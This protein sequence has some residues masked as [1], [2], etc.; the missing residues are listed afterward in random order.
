VKFKA[1]KKNFFE[2]WGFVRRGDL[3]FDVGC[4]GGKFTH[5]F[6]AI[7]ARVVCVEADERNVKNMGAIYGKRIEL[8][9][10][11]LTDHVGH[12]TLFTKS[13]RGARATLVPHIYARQKGIATK[14][15]DKKTTVCAVTVDSLAEKY[16]VPAFIK[17]DIEG[18]EYLALKGMTVTVPALMFE[19][20]SGYIEE[21]YKCAVLLGKR[22][23]EFNYASGHHGTFEND[24][25][26]DADEFE[27]GIPRR[28]AAGKFTWGNVY[29]RLKDERN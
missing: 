21:A 25:W 1:R 4:V 9:H 27:I 7:G 18:S 11:A 26:T 22:G 8:V 3:V 29:A 28:D 16:G 6:L 5:Q 17:L 24:V 23:Y 19:F 20:A 15:Y 2:Y 12:T 10:A 14:A 13:Q